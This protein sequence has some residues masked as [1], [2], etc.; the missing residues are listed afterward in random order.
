M[1]TW[2]GE[3]MKNDF[4]KK[5]RKLFGVYTIRE[6]NK[7]SDEDRKKLIRLDS[8]ESVALRKLFLEYGKR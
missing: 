1:V 5:I 8:E 6:A 7:L 2:K 4:A 3:E